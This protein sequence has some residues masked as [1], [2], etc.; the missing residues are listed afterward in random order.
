MKNNNI[1]YFPSQKDS[2]N[3]KKDGKKMIKI[4]ATY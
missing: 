2:L 1:P 3:N 4:N